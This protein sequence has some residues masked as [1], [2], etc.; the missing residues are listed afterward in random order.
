MGE[1]TETIVIVQ[2][3]KK[4]CC[5]AMKGFESSEAALRNSKSSVQDCLAFDVCPAMSCDPID[6]RSCVHASCKRQQT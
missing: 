2:E 3:M 6:A 1:A 5:V 4:R